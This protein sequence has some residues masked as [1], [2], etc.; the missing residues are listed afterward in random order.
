L[1]EEFARLEHGAGESAARSAGD[2]LR[3]ILGG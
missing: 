1:I 3:D 2:R